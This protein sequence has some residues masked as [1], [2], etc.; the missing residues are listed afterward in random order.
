MTSS[1]D[2][3]PAIIATG[4]NI[5]RGL[6]ALGVEAGDIVCVHS[7]MKSLGLVIGGSRAVVEALVDAVS[8]GGT[9]M[10]PTYSGDLSDPA[11][12]RYPPVAVDRLHEVR[13][14]M[15]AYDP[16]RSPTRGL[17]QVAEYFRTYPDVARSPHPQS[18]FAALGERALELVSNHPFDNRFGPQSPLGRLCDAG[19]KVLLLG[20]PYDTV[21]LFHMIQHLVG[22]SAVVQ[23][24][25]PVIDRGERRWVSYSDIDYPIDWFNAGVKALINSGIAS[26]GLVSAAPSVLFPAAE[27]VTFLVD[28]RHEHGFVPSIAGPELTDRNN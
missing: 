10:M 12:W 21:S 19:G 15:P 24:A 25:A 2:T 23:K 8:P 22:E 7:S 9:V 4:A 28:W 17:G 3:N 27:A 20:A 16:A 26:T 5:V 18:S 6:R 14:Q 1:T 11:E 13:A